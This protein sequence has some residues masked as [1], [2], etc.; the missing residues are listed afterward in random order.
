MKSKKNIIKY[1]LVFLLIIYYGFEAKDMQIIDSLDFFKTYLDNFQKYLFMGT[2]ITILL[3]PTKN[4]NY[5]NPEIK[6]R[7]SNNMF[8][9]IWFKNIEEIIINTFFII[10]SFVIISSFF[11]YNNPISIISFVSFM[12]IFLFMLSCYVIRDFWYFVTGK[13]YVGYTVT[14]A[15]NYLM[16]IVVISI[17]YYFKTNTFTQESLL[18]ILCIYECIINIIG[19]IYLY[20]NYN[21][22]EI[23]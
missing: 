10:F 23:I 2:L 19:L 7:L 12:R 16:L 3:M 6:I 20:I 5:L 22:K 1:L 13:N 14:V 21:K 9:Y 18:F 17:N 15:S 11:G 4:N 8:K